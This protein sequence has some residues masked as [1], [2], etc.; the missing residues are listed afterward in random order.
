[1]DNTFC[2][3]RQLWFLIGDKTIKQDMR[4]IFCEYNTM[5][6][7]IWCVQKINISYV[8]KNKS[9]NKQS[10]FGDIKNTKYYINSILQGWQNA[11]MSLR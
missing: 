8:T 2:E 6:V 5:T 3:A 7:T 10:S 1:M 11:I 9:T 4:N